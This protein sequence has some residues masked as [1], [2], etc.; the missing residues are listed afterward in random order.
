MPRRKAAPNCSVQFWLSAKPDC[1]EGRFIQVGNSLLL[2]PE[3]QR[4]SAGARCLYLCCAMES[5]GRRDFVLPQSA[6]KKYGFCP[7]SLRRYLKELVTA[8]FINVEICGRWT[9]ENNRYVFSLSWRDQQ[10][11]TNQSPP[12][13]TL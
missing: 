9:R 11:P 4:L 1:R 6:G 12:L 8:G 5:G 2:S 3:F 7:S 13:A 10:S